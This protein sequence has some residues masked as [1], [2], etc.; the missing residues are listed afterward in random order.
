MKLV[1]FVLFFAAIICADEIQ[2]TKATVAEIAK[3]RTSDKEKMTFHLENVYKDRV[4][5]ANNP[6]PKLIM[7]KKYQNEKSFMKETVT[8]KATLFYLINDADIYDYPNENIVDK[9]KKN[10]LFTSNQ[11]TLNWIKIT[12][13][14][15]AKRWKKVTN[16]IWIKKNDTIEKQ[17]VK[18]K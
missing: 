13:E 6:F 8:F 17:I 14:F 5:E 11:K 18:N 9:W 4:Y 1:W 7:K 3:L 2:R 10:R 15:S 16:A 12:G